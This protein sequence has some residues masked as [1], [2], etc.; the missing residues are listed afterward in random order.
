MLA[1]EVVRN[2]HRVI[3]H[4]PN[5]LVDM[6]DQTFGKA[7][8]QMLLKSFANVEAEHATLSTHEKC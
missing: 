7:V 6:A 3:E 2:E 8:Q 5:C 4:V 1:S